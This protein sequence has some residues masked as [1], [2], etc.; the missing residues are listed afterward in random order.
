MEINRLSSVSELQ[1]KRQA[2]LHKL[3]G[4]S[5]SSMLEKASG[6]EKPLQFSKHAVN[7][8]NERGLSFTETLSEELSKA[9]DKAREKGAKDVVVI[10]KQSA[11]IVN[12]P[13][14]TVITAMDA[15]EMK[16]NI[17]TKI[18]SAVIL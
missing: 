18:D 11:F 5:F 2:E 15:L 12:I 13:N 14:N 4:A 6:T 3:E 16:E 17:F 10:G 7:R 8:M 1:L 9:V